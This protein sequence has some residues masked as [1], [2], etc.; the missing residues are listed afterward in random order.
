MTPTEKELL[1]AIHGLENEMV[2]RIVK[3]EIKIDDSVNGRFKDNE[4][5]LTALENN[6]NKWAWGI[7][8]AVMVAVMALILK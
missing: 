7:I 3:L 4:R 6:Q 8:S 1:S 2:E 5:R